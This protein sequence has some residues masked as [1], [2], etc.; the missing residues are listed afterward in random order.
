M[1]NLPKE[2][3]ARIHSVL[4]EGST[5]NQI[6]RMPSRQAVFDID[7]NTNTAETGYIRKKLVKSV[8]PINK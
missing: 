1:Q 8:L 7:I 4:E 5:I 6:H 3:I 2:I